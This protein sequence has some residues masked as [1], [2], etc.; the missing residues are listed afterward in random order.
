MPYLRSYTR[1]TSSVSEISVSRPADQRE[2][3]RARIS[4]PLSSSC[5]WGVDVAGDGDAWGD[6]GGEGRAIIVLDWF[7]TALKG[8]VT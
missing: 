5:S 3:R 6:S 2:R 4:L 7:G 1:W 8:F